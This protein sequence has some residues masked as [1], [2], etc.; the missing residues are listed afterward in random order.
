MIFLGL[1]LGIGLAPIAVASTAATQTALSVSMDNSGP[2]TK[3]TLT[4]RVTG[5]G[6][7]EVP[8]G[9]VNFRS[10]N[11]DLG[12]AVIDGDGNAVLT[13]DNLTAGNHHVTG[14]Y[15][16]DSAHEELDL[17]FHAS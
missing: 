14:I 5:T 11:N 9:V 1:V 16:G 4:A 13:T 15:Q 2:R 3:V 12:S 8:K 6:G 17:V 10:G 7:S